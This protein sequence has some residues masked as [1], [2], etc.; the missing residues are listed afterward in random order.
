[1]SKYKVGDKVYILA[2]YYSF[3]LGTIATI[4]HIYSEL[5]EHP[6]FEITK[7]GGIFINLESR[8]FRKLSK[9][10]KAMK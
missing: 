1:M 3:P 7:L 10:E 4:T 6:M 2:D 8:E 5:H 9:L